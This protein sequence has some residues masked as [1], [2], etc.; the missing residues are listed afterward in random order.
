MNNKSMQKD[1]VSKVEIDKQIQEILSYNIKVKEF[2]KKSPSL[3]PLQEQAIRVFKDRAQRNKYSDQ[4][5]NNQVEQFNKNGLFLLKRGVYVRSNNRIGKPFLDSEAI[6]IT[7]N[8]F[9]EHRT[10]FNKEAKEENLDIREYNSA[11]VKDYHKLTIEEKAAIKEFRKEHRS[12][13]IREYNTKVEQFNSKNDF[14]VPKKTI[15]TLKNLSSETVMSVI[16]VFYKGFFKEYIAKR[17]K[18]LL[19][20]SVSKNKIPKLKLNISSFAKHN[21][22]NV[23]RL[24]VNPLTIRNHF[25]ILREANV[26]QN[27]SYT[28]WQ[29]ASFFNINPDILHI[30][31]GKPPQTQYDVNQSFKSKKDATIKDIKGSVLLNIKENKRKGDVL[32]IR[33]L[34]TGSIPQSSKTSPA[35]SY[36]NT[37][38]IIDKNKNLVAAK[39][40]KRKEKISANARLLINSDVDFA[41]N[42]FNGVYKGKSFTPLRRSRIA[43]IRNESDLSWDEMTNLLTQDFIKTAYKNIYQHHK[44][45]IYVG[46][47]Y[48][49]I[50]RVKNDWIK[51]VLTGIINGASY[52]IFDKMEVFRA[53]LVIAGGYFKKNPDHNP[54]FPYSYFD[55]TRTLPKEMGFKGLDKAYERKKRKLAERKIEKKRVSNAAYQRKKKIKNELLMKEALS[56]FF[57]GKYNFEELSNYVHQNLG[58]KQQ[59]ELAV[60]LQN[61][62]SVV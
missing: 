17:E 50:Q 26:I 58:K 32:D 53:K 3:T 31:D 22:L 41:N 46:E 37:K 49:T 16:V 19:S 61:N 27:Y 24:G 43:D 4:E 6:H 28:N 47:W 57:K 7:M 42:L 36:K 52:D 59:K 45:T 2:L 23:P 12:L 5:Y 1:T 11:I 51:P 13:L 9:R 20:T 29:S 25:K 55:L 44:K 54:L 10:K 33:H 48:K 35:V 60:Y 21:Y 30:K 14:I 34:I 38:A 40:L 56:K 15:V 62:S 18:N 8:K 39:N